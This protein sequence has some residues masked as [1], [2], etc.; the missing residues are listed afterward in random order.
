MNNPYTDDKNREAGCQIWD[1]KVE[2]GIARLRFEGSD[3]GIGL[4]RSALIQWRAWESP[5]ST[6]TGK[7]KVAN[8]LSKTNQFQ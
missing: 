6:P 4:K 7:A 8:S 3:G 5:R 1:T 2:V